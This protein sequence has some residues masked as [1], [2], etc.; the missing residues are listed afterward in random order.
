ME[1][2]IGFIVIVLGILGAALSRQL[3]DECKAWTP[4]I[5]RYLINRAINKLPD[6]ERVRFEEEWLAHVNELP[7][8]VGKIIAALGLLSAAQR[9]SLRISAQKRRSDIVVSII[10]IFLVVPIMALAAILI[11]ASDGGPTLIKQKQTWNGQ[12]VSIWKFRTENIAGRHSLVGQ[13]LKRTDLD[14]LPT[15][16]SVLC[17]DVTMPSWPDCKRLLR[18]RFRR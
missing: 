12:T 5:I 1:L 6:E 17:G 8:E 9:I 4:W 13:F 15:L 3:T 11:K 14:A 16:I 18:R 2:I 7:G 10:L